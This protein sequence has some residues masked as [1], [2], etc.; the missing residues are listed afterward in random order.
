[1]ESKIENDI[2]SLK[3]FCASH[4]TLH[5]LIEWRDSYGIIGRHLGVKHA[6]KLIPMLI[7]KNSSH[8]WLHQC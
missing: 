6:I 7:I 8:G 1:M 3:R 2:K 4:T 5:S